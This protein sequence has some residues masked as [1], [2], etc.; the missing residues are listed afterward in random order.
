MSAFAVVGLGYWGP[1]LLRNVV[2]HSGGAEVVAV[3]RSVDRLAEACANYPAVACAS[4]LEQAL[5]EHDLT[6]VVVATP[7]STHHDLAR[8]A[9]DAGCHVLVEKPLAASVEE[10]EDLVARAQVAGRTLMVGHTFLFSPRVELIH[11]LV[12]A[13]RLGTIQYVT[14][15]RLNLG[16]HQAD[17]S[18]IWDLAP[19]DLSIICHVLG[20]LPD[21][22][23]TSGRGMVHA[24]RPDVAFLTLTFPS[25]VVAQVSLS[26]L[27]PS[28]A[29][30]MVVVGDQQMLVYD[31]IDN[32]QP[33]KLYDKGV[34]RPEPGD[35]GEHQ[36]TY[37]HGDM[38]APH[39]VAQEP[40]ARE[41]AHFVACAAGSQQCRCDGWFGLGVVR[42]LEAAERS[43]LLGGDVVPLAS[44]D[45]D[46]PLAVEARIA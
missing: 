21:T 17:V 19:H 8:T 11:D 44:V 46:R 4:S 14:S 45:G 33:I 32:E 31:D 35:F 29:R 41:V 15:A 27:A 24:D 5:A 22:V 13:G 40:L 12:R 23:R 26:W 38:L 25:G 6:G 3:D 2:A 20:E 28:K 37:R 10:A 9:L 36:L 34:T 30:N 7:V 1:N 18:V 16:L 39:V 43:W 42:V